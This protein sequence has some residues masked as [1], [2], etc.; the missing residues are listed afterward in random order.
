M[1]LSDVIFLNTYTYS[2]FYRRFSILKEFVEF[3]LYTDN[4]KSLPI[5][6]R[7]D[8]FCFQK[9]ILDEDIVAFKEW[10]EDF[11]KELISSNDVYKVFSDIEDDFKKCPLFVLY[12]PIDLSEKDLHS[13]G[14]WVKDNI[15]KKAFISLKVDS[16]IGVGC[17]FSWRNSL[18]DMSFKRMKRKKHKE[19][20]N[21][22][23]EILN[24]HSN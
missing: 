19:I 6:I 15:N 13:I 4:D 2:N 16:N 8:R 14:K 1:S 3:L 7:F 23:N 20:Y 18:Y 11:F 9:K 17:F 5:L 24:S 21:R 12:S 10:G 22:V